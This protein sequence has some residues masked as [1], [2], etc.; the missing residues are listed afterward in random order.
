M[1]AVFLQNDKQNGY[2]QSQLRTFHQNDGFFCGVV[3]AT[4]M[5]QYI[6]KIYEQIFLSKTDCCVLE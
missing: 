1:E 5:K 3:M 6:I 2:N 4:N